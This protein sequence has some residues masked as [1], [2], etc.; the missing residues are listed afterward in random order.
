M[1][2]LLFKV[3]E[4]VYV[5]ENYIGIVK[6]ILI[7]DTIAYEVTVNGVN[8]YFNEKVITKKTEN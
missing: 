6:G 8:Y 1:R 5:C 7:S 3:G 4:E 2:K